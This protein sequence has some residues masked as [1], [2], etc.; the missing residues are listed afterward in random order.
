MFRKQSLNL[1]VISSR[2]E[3]ALKSFGDFQEFNIDRLKTSEA[4][5]LIKKIGNNNSK[6]LLLIEQLK[7]ESRKELTEFLE[8]PLLISLLYKKFEHRETI[9]LKKQEFYSEVYEA[10]FQAHD[11]VKGDR[12]ERDKDSNL[13]LH[14]FHKILRGLA[15]FTALLNQVEFDYNELEKFLKKLQKAFFLA[16]SL[17][18]RTLLMI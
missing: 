7:Q 2:P 8:S 12:Y 3:S 5:E 17:K 11:I 4:Y 15:Y 18:F 6:S 1:F 13:S 16:Y 14:E 9:P 10:L